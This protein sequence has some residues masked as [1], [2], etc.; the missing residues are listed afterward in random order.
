MKGSAVVLVVGLACL[1]SA[2]ASAAGDLTGEVYFGD[3]PPKFAVG[4][5]LTGH[6]IG[7]INANAGS[8]FG[9][10]LGFDRDFGY[11]FSVEYWITP[12][13]SVELA[14]DHVKIEDTYGAARTVD[15]GIDD[16]GLSAK[17][18]FMP[19]A[20]LRPYVLGGFDAFMTD[21]DFSG[22]GTLLVTGDVDNTWGWHLGAG[23]EYRFTDN[24]GCFA[25]IRYRA[26]DTDVDVTQ[27]FSAIP[28]VTT[29][30]QV[31]YDGFM[32]AIGVKVYW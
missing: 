2:S 1:L 30:D 14:F 20:R 8:Y 13:L 7:G 15:L 10:D 11:G 24:L 27:W 4:F 12:S 16:W 6:E 26:G 32:A 17:W 3:V 5:R 23:A 18:T 25:E 22:T 28:A 19:N 31:E 29:T 9:G 21:I